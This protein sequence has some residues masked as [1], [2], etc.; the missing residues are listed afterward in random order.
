MPTVRA[1][2]LP[3]A[4][5]LC[6]RQNAKKN[7]KCFQ[8]KCELL[9]PSARVAVTVASKI[10]LS[11]ADVRSCRHFVLL[12]SM[13]RVALAVGKTSLYGA[14]TA[15][16]TW[17]NADSKSIALAVGKATSCSYRRSKQG[18][19][20]RDL[21]LL[22]ASTENLAGSRQQE[23]L[24]AL[25]Q[26]DADGKSKCDSIGNSRADGNINSPP[27]VTATTATAIRTLRR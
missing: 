8:K 17:C 9:L 18:A 4:C 12:S 2:L 15:T 22:S 19:F 5:C 26:L 20:F 25:K 13:R 27:T 24:V 11:S 23:Q 6:C 3:S 10:A 7:E 1:M 21:L 14:A 16:A